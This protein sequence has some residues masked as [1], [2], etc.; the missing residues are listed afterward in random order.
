MDNYQE[1]VKHGIMPEQE[2]M[3]RH[4]CYFGLVTEGLLKQVKHENMCGALKVASEIAEK[5]LKER[6]EMRSEC[7]GKDLGP[8][9]QDLI[10]GL[11]NN[12]PTTRTTIDQ[13]LAHIWWQEDT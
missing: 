5:E 12:D 1:L 3:I 9:A 13:V 6:P 2:I 4:F 10:S 8:A 7:W 11:T